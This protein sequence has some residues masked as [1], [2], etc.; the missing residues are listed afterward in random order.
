MAR[1]DRPHT[2]NKSTSL[3]ITVTNVCLSARY[4]KFIADICFL[5][6]SYVSDGFASH[7][8]ITAQGHCSKGYVA[9]SE[10]Q[11]GVTFWFQ[12]LTT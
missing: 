9:D 6:S 5:L 11:Y 12:L 1:F 7:V 3:S 8:K 10:I 4:W 2:T